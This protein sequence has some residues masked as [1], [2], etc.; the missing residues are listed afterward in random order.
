M[1][2]EEARLAQEA[3]NQQA[4]GLFSLSL[5]LNQSNPELSAKLV[6]A[7]AI[8]SYMPQLEAAA[9]AEQFAIADQQR[10]DVAAREYHSKDRSNR[11]SDKLVNA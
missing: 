4:L 3:A 11:D 2:A 9:A 1:A 6:E 5:F 7:A 10:R 8:A